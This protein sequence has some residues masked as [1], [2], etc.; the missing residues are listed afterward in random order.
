VEYLHAYCVDNCLV[1]VADPL[2]IGYCLQKNAQ[3]G[4]K[5]VRK[6]LP[7]EPVGVVCRVNGKFGVVEYSEIGKEDSEKYEHVL[8]SSNY[9]K[10]LFDSQ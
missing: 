6:V 5:V 4:A 7:Q 2:F 1:R 3:C 9:C 8:M 10:N